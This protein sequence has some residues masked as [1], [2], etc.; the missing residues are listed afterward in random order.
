M[1]TGGKP[2]EGSVRCS[3]G[4]CGTDSTS[5]IWFVPSKKSQIYKNEHHYLLHQ[6]NGKK[7]SKKKCGCGC[8]KTFYSNNPEKNYIKGHQQ[9]SRCDLC[10][11]DVES[12][13]LRLMKMNKNEFHLCERCIENINNIVI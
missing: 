2:L 11:E 5:G 3:C 7:P 12:D 9:H 13:L 8:G 6:Y 10:L 4:Y 1:S